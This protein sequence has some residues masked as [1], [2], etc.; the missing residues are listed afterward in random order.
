MR[1]EDL[2]AARFIILKALTISELR[3]EIYCQLIRMTEDNPN[4][5][6]PIYLPWP[7][8]LLFIFFSL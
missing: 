6:K 4:M 8:L 5:Y 7:I 3:D 1:S 2:A